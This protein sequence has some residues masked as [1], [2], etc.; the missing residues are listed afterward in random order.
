MPFSFTLQ[1]V[2][3]HTSARAGLW[4][5]PHGVVQTPAFMPVG[6]Q[7]TVKG[8]LPEQLKAVGVQKLLANT[9]HL[10]LRPGAEVIADLGGLHRFMDWDRPILTDSG[11]FQVFSL[12]DLRRMSDEHVVFKSHIDGS[13]L[14]LSPE[15]AIRI[16]EL[17]GADV[18]MCLDECPPHGV[19]AEK[20]RD[21]VDRTTRWAARCREAHRRADQALFGIV[22]GGTDPSLRERSATS[23]V[24]LDFPGYAIGGLSVGETPESMYATLDMT[25]PILPHEKPRYL[26]GVGTPCDLIEAVLRGVDLFDCVMPTRNGRN[27]T[28]FTSRGKVK[29]RNASHR[30]D[31]SPL[32]PECDCPTCTRYTR[33]YLRHLFVAEEMLGPILASL[34]NVAFYQRLMQDLRQAIQEGR[35]AEFRSAQLAAWDTAV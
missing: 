21:A 31:E 24:P 9:Y 2:D 11:G 14:A 6:T 34:H 27:A 1:A 29:L 13:E 22:Q 19:D 8:L 3:P 10:A 26:M 32:D 4:S 23:L 18:I 28:A 12:A 20:L 25:T 7:A 16:Q 30:A 15:R 35:A 5:T 33:A 17:L